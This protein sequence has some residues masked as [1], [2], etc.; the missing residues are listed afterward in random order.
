[1][2]RLTRKGPYPGR[3]WRLDADDVHDTRKTVLRGRSQHRRA[4]CGFQSWHMLL[5]RHMSEMGHERPI[6]RCQRG[7]PAAL[8][9]VGVRLNRTG[10][11]FSYCRGHSGNGRRS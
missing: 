1:M 7:A 9:V 3:H 5:P 6:R 8:Y 4:T 10:T 2:G 11:V